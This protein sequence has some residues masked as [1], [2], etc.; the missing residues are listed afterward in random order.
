M[1]SPHTPTPADELKD[2]IELK[3]L[4]LTHNESTHTKESVEECAL[5]LIQADRTALCE[6]ILAAQERF[7]EL[8]PDNEWEWIEAVP[9]AA[10]KKI[11]EKKT[12]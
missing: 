8:M 2:Q 12:G 6:A 4:W 10:I 7:I 9:V 1:I 11:M 5:E 3:F